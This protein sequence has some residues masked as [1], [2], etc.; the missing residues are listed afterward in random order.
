MSD[1]NKSN[2]IKVTVT[3]AGL[4]AMLGGAGDFL[5]M[6]KPDA[7]QVGRAAD[8]VNRTMYENQQNINKRL[9]R[10]ETVLEVSMGVKFDNDGFTEMD[11]AE[12]PA[13]VDTPALEAPPVPRQ[14][15][16]R[17]AGQPVAAM[18][19][20]TPPA[21]RARRPSAEAFN[22]VYQEKQTHLSD[23]QMIEAPPSL[24]EEG[25]QKAE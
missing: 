18:E 19:V 20:P 22:E 17:G 14:R 7:E 21:P 6:F 9:L 15:R 2:S 25:G 12:E 24:L 3:V 11:P 16:P 10:L 23:E 1:E 5:A 13:P 4:A 8:R